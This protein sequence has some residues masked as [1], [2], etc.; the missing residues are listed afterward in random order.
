MDERE[1]KHKEFKKELIKNAPFKFIWYAPER[2][3]AHI[4]KTKNMPTEIFLYNTQ[5]VALPLRF[6]MP[7][8]MSSSPP[9]VFEIQVNSTISCGIG[10]YPAM[11]DAS[12]SAP[13]DIFIT[14]ACFAFIFPAIFTKVLQ[15]PF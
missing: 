3:P 7:S 2:L 5:G 10:R 14:A 8:Q 9:S 11:T 1:K 12:I 13:T 15:V 6:K 4:A